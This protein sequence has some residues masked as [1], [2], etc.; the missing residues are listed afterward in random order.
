[1]DRLNH[2]AQLIQG[3]A[4]LNGANGA[5][6]RYRDAPDAPCASHLALLILRFS[7][8]NGHSS[9]P[10]AKALRQ[11]VGKD[12]KTRGRNSMKH[13]L[14]ASLVVCALA[15][16]LPLPATAQQEPV[17]VPVEKAAYH[18]PVFRNEH[19]MALRVYFPPGRGSNYH[20]HSTDQISVQVEAGA[21]SGQVLGEQPTP[22]R[23]G[24]RGS[25]S[26]TAYSKKSF[27]HKSTNMGTTPFHNIVIALLYPEPGRFTASSRAD[28]PGYVQVLDNERVRAWRVVLEP[29]QSVAAIT[30]KAPGL[31][32]VIDGGEIAEVI[33]GEP[34]RGQAL[35]LGDFYWQ[36]PSPPRGIRNI[37]T[38]RVEFVEFELK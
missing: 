38:S 25:V 33:P 26:F 28:V 4:R 20:I 2:R 31:R 13:L 22:A 21:N 36:D 5:P 11:T 7:C 24:T 18:W 12:G 37:G 9:D 27:T 8:A 32:V 34:D 3:R 16:A 23:P 10:S 17:A 14:K 35:R 19:V 30:Q 15:P 6:P 29:G 1:M